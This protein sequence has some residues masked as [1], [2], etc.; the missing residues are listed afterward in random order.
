MHSCSATPAPLAF[1]P[2][3]T[4][5]LAGGSVALARRRLRRSVSTDVSGGHWCTFADRARF[6][7]HR[8]D[9]KGGR[10]AALIWRE[11]HSG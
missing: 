7:S 6:Y 4:R 9:G 11:T 8:R 3:C 5:P 2:Q 10:M 1:R